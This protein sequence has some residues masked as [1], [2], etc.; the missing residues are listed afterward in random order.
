LRARHVEGQRVPPVLINA[1][2]HLAAHPAAGAG[3]DPDEV[4]TLDDVLANVQSAGEG[5]ARILRA[6]A[7]A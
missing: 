4:I 2:A 1:R 7:E 5:V 6:M 3:P